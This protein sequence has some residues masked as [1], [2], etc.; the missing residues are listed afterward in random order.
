[1]FEGF[2]EMQTVV[3]RVHGRLDL[4]G[5]QEYRKLEFGVERFLHT[6]EPGSRTVQ[7]ED[8]PKSALLRKFWKH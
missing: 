5:E 4:G 2:L 8:K 3:T 7:A 1:M 6:P